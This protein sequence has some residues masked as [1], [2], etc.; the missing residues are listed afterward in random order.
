M[1]T[2]PNPTTT[3]PLPALTESARLRYAT[4]MALYFAQGVPAG[5]LSF[6]IPA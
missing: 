2:M 3:R 5:V 4:F 6:A 1:R